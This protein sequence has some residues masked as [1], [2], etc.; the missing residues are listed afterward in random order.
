LLKKHHPEWWEDSI[1]SKD[2]QEDGS[3]KT[4]HYIPIPIP[5]YVGGEKTKPIIKPNKKT[6]IDPSVDPVPDSTEETLKK[7]VDPNKPGS[8]E[9]TIG[10][11]G[12]PKNVTL[13][14]TAS[15]LYTVYNPTINE[16]KDFG[17][18]LWSSNFV[19]QILKVFSN[20]MEAIIGLHKI[21]ANPI[22]GDKHNIKVGYLDSGVSANVVTNQ[23]VD[24]DCGSII[25]PEVYNS[26]V[27]YNSELSLYLPFI[28]I[29]RLNTGDV[30]NSVL[31]V[32]YHVDV[33]TG[34]T[35]VD[36]H[37][38]KNA[39][40]A[41]MY[42]YS[43]NCAET[44]PLSSGSYMGIV[45]N[46]TG[47]AASIGATVAT[48]GAAAPLVAGSA[49]KLLDHGTSVQRSG[50]ISGNA[51]AMAVKKPYLIK[52]ENLSYIPSNISAYI[53]ES[54]IIAKIN[55]CSGFTVCDK[56]FFSDSIATKTESDEIESLLKSG[57]I[58]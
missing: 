54:N 34:A 19:D 58:V 37:V 21:Y 53:P 48:G 31:R 47:L 8:I 41:I 22:V 12:T 38:T 39:T 55:S 6:V 45:S 23:Y 56:V 1:E 26:A 20:P 44:I 10:G 51:G 46:V 27:D 52:T 50:S 40:D 57:V 28:G 3:T 16:I 43:G 36:V 18:W 49:L 11:G 9:G 15:A 30:I 32:V 25:I 42:M 7:I 2:P 4:S 5:D 14:G 33:T 13:K 35:M 17:K 29:V 24:V